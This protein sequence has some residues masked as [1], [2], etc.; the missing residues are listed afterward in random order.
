MNQQAAKLAYYRVL[1][2]DTNLAKMEYQRPDDQ[3]CVITTLPK[4]PRPSK[5]R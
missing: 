1:G 3:P 5:W 2:S 4:W